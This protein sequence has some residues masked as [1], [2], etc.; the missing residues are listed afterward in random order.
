M[1][2]MRIRPL[3]D[4]ALRAA[5]LVLAMAWALAASHAVWAEPNDADFAL[6]RDAFH[7]GDSTRLDRIAPRLKAICSN[8]TSSIGSFG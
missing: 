8:R 6:A 3:P 5:R 1:T 4:F 2:V 7:A